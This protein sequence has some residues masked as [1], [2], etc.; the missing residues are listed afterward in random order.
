MNDVVE[1]LRDLFDSLENLFDSLE[2]E[3]VLMTPS[4]LVEPSELDVL[5]SDIFGLSPPSAGLS[6]IVL[7]VL[8]YL[9]KSS[10]KSTRLSLR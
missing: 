2:S 3:I 4:E 7:F 5:V 6:L 10:F 1:I 9:M 8:C